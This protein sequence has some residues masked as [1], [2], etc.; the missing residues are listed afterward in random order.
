MLVIFVIL[1]FLIKLEDEV[2]HEKKPPAIFKVSGFSFRR[3]CLFLHF[4]GVLSFQREDVIRM[5]KEI[6][7]KVSL[8]SFAVNMYRPGNT[9]VMRDVFLCECLDLSETDISPV[10]ST[11][12]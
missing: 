4:V 10:M 6:C 12:L 3:S 8:R 2:L 9:H 5:I 7:G 11:A 1:M